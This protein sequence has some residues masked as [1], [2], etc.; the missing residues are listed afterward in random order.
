M[1][2]NSMEGGRRIKVEVRGLPEARHMLLFICEKM[3]TVR[4]LGIK[5]KYVC[6]TELKQKE[7][8]RQHLFYSRD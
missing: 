8:T 6:D 3:N 2:M 7:M 4:D 1:I 5:L